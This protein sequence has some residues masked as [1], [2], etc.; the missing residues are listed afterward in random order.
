MAGPWEPGSQ[1]N[2]HQGKLYAHAQQFL[3]HKVKSAVANSREGDQDVARLIL[4]AGTK[5]FAGEDLGCQDIIA[6]GSKQHNAV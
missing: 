4:V 3:R 5:G 1:R 6:D 2:G